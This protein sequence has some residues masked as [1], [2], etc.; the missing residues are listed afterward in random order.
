MKNLK[1]KAARAA[2]TEAA[3]YAQRNCSKYFEF[4]FVW[5]ELMSRMENDQTLSA[6][7]VESAVRR[8]RNVAARDAAET[9]SVTTRA[10]RPQGRAA[11]PD[12]PAGGAAVPEQAAFE[13]G[14]P[15]SSR[16]AGIDPGLTSEIRLNIEE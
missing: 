6:A 7:L 14:V 3:V 13:G 15:V 1:L 2:R 10:A 16:Y 12:A 11:V 4:Q 9:A 8:A 5:P